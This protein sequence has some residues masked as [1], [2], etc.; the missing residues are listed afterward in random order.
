MFEDT[1][2][3][4]P[5]GLKFDDYDFKFAT[6]APRKQLKDLTSLAFV[7]RKTT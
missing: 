5:D 1:S 6:E 3:K 2:R 7:L 4:L